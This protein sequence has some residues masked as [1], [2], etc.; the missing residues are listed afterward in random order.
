[1]V[2]YGFQSIKRTENRYVRLY[3]KPVLLSEIYFYVIS[4]CYIQMLA[5]FG[6]P[7]KLISTMLG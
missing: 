6:T 1:M 5:R 7:A 4:N 3:G 2:K